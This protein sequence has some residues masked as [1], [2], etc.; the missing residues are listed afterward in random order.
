MTLLP[1]VRLG[2]YEIT[3]L[4]DA[5]GMG[6]VYK[7]RDTR[8]GRTVAIKILPDEVNSDPKRRAR[9]ESEAKTIAGLNHP[10]IC[11]LL[12]VGELRSTDSAQAALYLVMEHVHGETLAARLRRGPLPLDQALSVATEI[13]DAL[14]T[15]H[16]HHV[17]HRDLKPGNVM[18][19]K[20]GA[21]L[22]DFGLAKLNAPPEESAPGV[23]SLSTQEPATTPGE[24][25]GT[26]PYMAPEQLE[27]KETDPRSDIF[28]FGALLYEMLTGKRAFAGESRAS[29]ISAIMS[30]EPAPVSSL[31][32][33]ASPL[34][35]RLVARC[36]A[37]D[38]DDRWDSAHDVADELRWI[39]AAEAKRYTT[40]SSGSSR[41]RWLWGGA[42]ALA[43]VAGLAVVWIVRDR[44]PPTHPA[45]KS[46]VLALPVGVAFFGHQGV[47]FSPDGTAVAYVGAADDGSGS[48]LYWHD[49]NRA[50]GL[51]MPGTEGAVQPFFSPDGGWLGF[52]RA[53]KLIKVQVRSGRIVQGSPAVELASATADW[54]RGVSWGDGGTILYAPQPV[55]GGL[56][57][58]SSD[59]GPPTELTRPDG[60]KSEL[61]H[62]W[63][64]VLPG[65]R[66][67]LFTA[68]HASGRQDRSAIAVVSLDTGRVAKLVD[69]G[70]YA[71]YVPTGHLVYGR[72][73][74]L[75]ALP[76]DLSTLKVTGTPTPVVN[77]V[78]MESFGGSG[79]ASF[80]L[81]STG[82]LVYAPGLPAMPKSS[83][84]WVDRDGQVESVT[85][86][87]R[88][89]GG[90]AT[91]SPDGQKLVVEIEEKSFANLWTYDLR[92]HR[93]QQLTFEGDNSFPAW[94]STGEQLAFASNRD[95]AFNL[96]VMRAD[97]ERP[98][99]RRTRS[100]NWQFPY[101]WSPDGRFLAYQE[102]DSN[103]GWST[104]I[105]PLEGDRKAWRWG[106]D[107]VDVTVPTFS[108]TRPWIAY[109]STESG[110]WEVWVRP[111]PGPGPRILAS[112][113]NGGR[114]PFWSQDGR[115]LFYLDDTRIMA[116]TVEPGASLRLSP[117]HLAFPLPFAPDPRGNAYHSP[118][119]AV[120]P[121]GRRVVVVRP[122]Q[123]VAPEIRQ[124]VVIPN[125][126]EE[127]KAGVPVKEQR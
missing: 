37:K 85:P 124:L 93:W 119:R 21:K 12:D 88:T 1:G 108:P 86:D 56:W 13:A 10:H 71:R 36:L 96:Y 34:L 17:I 69:G 8:L 64:Q 2:P 100:A 42:A 104:W 123:Q 78:A 80:A 24:V 121:D 15:A 47:A 70:S 62:R 3:E 118:F 54:T 23:S 49:L 44:R 29:V 120:T 19:A 91:L 75:L 101:S 14:T 76:F 40:V 110:R 11:T 99:E 81:S 127:V 102:V 33:M 30:A 122:D 116:A 79:S 65:G 77:G 18:L 67:A 52:I 83:L 48:R 22:L 109:Q 107:G 125:W 72:D 82:A 115:T 98:P 25:L 66:A 32:P 58:V 63:P 46:F 114:A 60:S 126:F 35:D 39:A 105:L 117:P 26:V 59:G 31:Q 87:Q 103:A 45:S 106:A 92:D 68:L 95:G 4:I 7:A 27:G 53:R 89:Y 90:R 97:G 74:S 51:P 9:F 84:I 113:A 111:F 20:S 61:S 55:A 28:S 94:S 73:G 112:G 38:R 6:E 57:R 5:G 43:L 16:R 41:V 50:E